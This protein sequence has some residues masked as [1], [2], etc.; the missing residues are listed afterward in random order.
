MRIIDL[1]QQGDQWLKWRQEGVT[2]TDAVILSGRSP[3][4]TVWRLWAE[5]VGYARPVD[6]SLNPLVQW[7]KKMEPVARSAAE[8][9]FNDLLM[10]ALV[11][12]KS[13]P[14]IRASLDALN[15][16]NEP[17]ELKAPSKKVWEEVSNQGS[18]SF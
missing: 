8:D 5:K 6:L 9:Y 1:P 12:S 7:G 16:N 18:S 14:I 10:P 3:Y 15:S 4:K 17:V 13:N 11:E 2:A